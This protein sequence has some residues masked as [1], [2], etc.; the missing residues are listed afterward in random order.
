MHIAD[1]FLR[2]S[3]S[4][5]PKESV[6]LD[7]SSLSVDIHMAVED[8]AEFSELVKKVILLGLLVEASHAE[9]ESFYAFYTSHCRSRY[10]ALLVHWQTLKLLRIRVVHFQIL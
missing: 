5:I 9:S 1:S 3:Q 10:L 2:L 8:F 7:I 6:S 4:F